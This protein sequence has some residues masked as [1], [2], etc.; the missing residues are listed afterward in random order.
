MLAR[1][2][3]KDLDALEKEIEGKRVAGKPSGSL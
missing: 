2:P 3:D 1:N